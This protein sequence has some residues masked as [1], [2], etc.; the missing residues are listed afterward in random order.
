MTVALDLFADNASTTLASSCLS[1]DTTLVLTSATGF[2]SPSAG[3]KYVATLEDSGGNIEVV[4]VTAMSGA[5][6]TVVRAQEGTSA[7]AFS[8]GTVFEMR[9]T[10]GEL[11]SFLQK[12]GG[13]TLAGT[14]TLTGVINA[15]S[16]GS[17]QGGEYAGGYIRSGP[18]VTSNQIRVPT[19]SPATAAGSVILT[20]ANIQSNLGSGQSLALSGMI[21]LWSGAIVDIPSG[22]VLCDGTNSTPDLRDSFVI[23]AGLTYAVDATGGST[24]TG[25]GN[26]SFSGV[27]T[28][29]HTLS[30]AEI[31]SH[32]HDIWQNLAFF[33][34]SAGPA[35][36]DR[37]D[38]GGS[39]HTSD[40]A[41][42]AN[43]IIKVTGG[44]GGHVHAL[45][46]LAA[47]TPHVHTNLPPYVALAYIMKT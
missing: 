31:P 42:G 21:V 45:T 10:A 25:N 44:G 43:P 46:A 35:Q 40:G 8:S 30:T 34:G 16:G 28:D 2:P 47:T 20:A 41:S 5:D 18:G 19:G 32:S 12:N 4:W 15:G 17:I 3:Q 36:A 7:L 26:L 11:A 37:T 22:W 24:N 29:S 14:T 38:T 6:A 33:Q 39:Y 13:D 1:T 9:V 27:T 23:G